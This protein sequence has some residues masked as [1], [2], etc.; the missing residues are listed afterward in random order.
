[1]PGAAYRPRHFCCVGSAA[2]AAAGI[3]RKEVRAEGQAVRRRQIGS[4]VG[5]GR[6]ICG[7]V[8]RADPAAAPGGIASAG[9]SR[10]IPGAAA[11]TV[12]AV[13]SAAAPTAPAVASA[14]APIGIAP[15]HNLFLHLKYCGEP[16][17]KYPM[18]PTDEMRQS[19]LPSCPAGPPGSPRGRSV[20]TQERAE[21]KE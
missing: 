16:P 15:A 4:G 21:G 17:Q 10:S 3:P 8:G 7:P 11:P 13:A 12:P 6:G 14:A 5:Q 18:F 19:I 2:A 9:I 1:M 20:K